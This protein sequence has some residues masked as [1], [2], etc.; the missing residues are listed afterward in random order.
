MLLC[1]IIGI[2]HSNSMSALITLSISFN[3]TCLVKVRNAFILSTRLKAGWIYFFKFLFRRALIWDI[4]RTAEIAWAAKSE[5]QHSV[6]IVAPVLHLYTAAE[7]Y[8]CVY[9]VAAI[10]RIE[11]ER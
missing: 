5:T 8:D 7:C 9:L 11:S 3:Q 6:K 2:L 4:K 10:V 1:C